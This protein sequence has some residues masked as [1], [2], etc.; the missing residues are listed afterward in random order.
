MT[1]LPQRN[2]RSSKISGPLRETLEKSARSPPRAMR[3]EPETQVE[4]SW[5][6]L[7]AGIDRPPDCVSV[8]NPTNRMVLHS[9][10]LLW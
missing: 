7:L 4:L 9:S 3:S 10:P 2:A 8:A 1:A 5:E 6:L